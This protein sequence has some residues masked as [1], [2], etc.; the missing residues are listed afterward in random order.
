[1]PMESIEAE[2]IIMV[3]TLLRIMKSKKSL[4]KLISLSYKFNLKKIS[5]IKNP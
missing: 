2:M 1:M 4:N 3:M 5:I